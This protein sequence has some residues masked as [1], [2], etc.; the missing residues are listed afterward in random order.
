MQPEEKL[1]ERKGNIMLVVVESKGDLKKA[2]AYLETLLASAR[3]D[4]LE[5]YGQM[6]VDALMSS[7]PKDSGS[8]A[9][10]WYYEIE[11]DGST[12]SIFFCNSN[13]NKGVPIAVILQYGHGTGTGGYVEGID[14][15]NPALEPVFSK[16][17]KDLWEEVTNL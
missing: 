7:T 15:I 16:L 14:Y 11:D 8:T 6:G 2:E 5:K 1:W 4:L 13:I 12:S 9:N 3:T 17:V 10:S